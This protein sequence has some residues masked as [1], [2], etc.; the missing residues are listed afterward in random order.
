M[1]TRTLRNGVY[2]SDVVPAPR[3]WWSIACNTTMQGHRIEDL[4]CGATR[5]SLLP[6]GRGDLSVRYRASWGIMAGRYSGQGAND[7]MSTSLHVIRLGKT[8]AHL[9]A[10]RNCVDAACESTLVRK[11]VS[12]H[13]RGIK[14]VGRVLR[15]LRYRNTSLLP[16]GGVGSIA[17]TRSLAIAC[18]QE[19]WHSMTIRPG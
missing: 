10:G 1:T 19:A 12:K 8:L 4:R 11:I 18:T 13:S 9:L 5:H 14:H 7:M 17:G 3:A 6:C 16:S 15:S 2:S